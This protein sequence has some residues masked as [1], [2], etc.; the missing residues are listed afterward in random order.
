M[1]KESLVRSYGVRVS[2]QDF[3]SCNPS[4]N[5]GRTSFF[6][7]GCSD[8]LSEHFHGLVTK[9]LTDFRFT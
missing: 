8:Y 7:R 2:T 1:P 9:F 5:L 6:T 4:S 3:E